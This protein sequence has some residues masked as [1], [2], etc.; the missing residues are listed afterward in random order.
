MMLEGAPAMVPT[1]PGSDH[2]GNNSNMTKF[3]KRPSAAALVITFSMLCALAILANLAFQIAR[4]RADIIAQHTR[5]ATVL[6]RV[7][8]EQTS[9]SLDAVELAL[10]ATGRARRLM[11]PDAPERDAVI[12]QLLQDSLARL[13]FVRAIWVLDA[14]GNM[15]HDSDH[16]P[17][18]YNLSERDYFKA[19]RDHAPPGLF[20]DKPRLSKLGVPFIG[21]SWRNLDHEGKFA[22]VSV[23][24][25]EPNY[26][27]R[28]F[29]AIRPGADG[30]VALIHD[31]G[32]LML[33]MPSAP[34]HGTGAV[35]IKRLVAES[36]GKVEGHFDAASVVDGVERTYFYRHVAR[37][38]LLVSIG[39]GRADMLAGWR[40]DSLAYGAASFGFLL[41]ICALATMAVRE[42]RSRHAMNQ[43]LEESD[44]AMKAA[45]SL[46]HI[47]SW[48]L[49]LDTLAG[50]WSD[51]M[52]RV[53]RLPPAPQPP[54]LDVFLEAIHPD[55]RAAL[56][57]AAQGARPWAGELRS[58]PANGPQRHFYSRGSVLK[59]GAGKPVAIVGTLQDVS[60]QRRASDQL[61]F[62]SHHD[63]LTRLP[64]RALLNDR[65]LQTIDAARP[66]QRQLAVLLLNVDR[67]KRVNEGIGH[68]AGDALLGE[69]GAR[70][71]ARLQPGD[72]L[73]RLG[74]DE[75]VMLL[76]RVDDS[77]DV[78][79]CA[80]QLLE[81]VARPFQLAGH[82][83]TVTASI[84]IA[85][86]PDDGATPGELIKNA[87]TALS[88]VKEGGRNSFRYFTGQM[89]IRAMHWMSLEHRLRGAL[90]KN[91][92]SLHYQ[93]QMALA[94]DTL[95]GVEALIRWHS[96]EL[97]PVSPV[98]FIPLA[99]D[100][101]LIL[102]IGEWVI[103]TA[104]AQARAWQDAGLAPIRIA[105]NVS[106]HQFMTGTVAAMVRA[107]LERAGLAPR[108]LAVELTESVLMKE[109]DLAMRQI[110]ELR[111]MGVIVALD[112]FGT[113]FSSLSYLS[114]FALDKIKIDQSLVR[115]IT[116]D[117]KSAAI[118][119]A[120]IGL[121]HGLGLTVVAE[122]VETQEQLA[123][124]RA[125]RCDEIQGYLFGRPV[126]APQLAL[127]LA[128][129]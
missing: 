7:L 87:D 18:K 110:A 57:E 96:G 65:L 88:H 60:E 56:V 43:A 104:C 107:A 122:G 74:S 37:R 82:E 46:A 25:L 4:A 101:G 112:D 40:R 13:P 11:G 85:L 99:E 92:L 81:L 94:G 72:T 36:V 114:R 53:L 58:N 69:I 9:A 61:Q 55:D 120:T 108:W 30:V 14:D 95:C 71:Q 124:L 41:L 33:R 54:P 66:Q 22:G 118:A 68:D 116:T 75:F 106:A 15:V 5:S 3:G 42:L 26:L 125:A 105:V 24:A 10:Q 6:A 32:T 67:L 48:R 128:P 39:Y 79:A 45:Q 129:V 47:G 1:T 97:G 35:S 117:P 70:L 84:G 19:H 29:D 113:G 64:N 76:T 44:A 12:E 102:P 62:L 91:E 86:Y 115:N 89:N 16:L 52:Y 90:A 50:Q 93:P 77:D 98:E 78:N 109:A 121:A 49:E 126:P 34:E 20:I 23:A 111:A 21:L 17:G 8:E 38:P 119:N 27:G 31:D 83:L 80:Q 28:Y 2:R 127:M 100:T 123:F 63:A 73:A 51:E 59:D 103:Q